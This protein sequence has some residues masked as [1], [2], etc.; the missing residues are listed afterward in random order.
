[1][2]LAKSSEGSDNG[3]PS[4][5]MSVTAMKV[6]APKR[7]AGSQDGR[8]RDESLRRKPRGINEKDND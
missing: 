6:K 4:A 3:V 5:K 1:M 2:W 8:P 7:S